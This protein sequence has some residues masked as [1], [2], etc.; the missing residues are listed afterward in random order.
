MEAG[1]DLFALADTSFI[2][3]VIDESNAGH[4]DARTLYKSLPDCI[5]LPVTV[6]PELAFLMGRSGGTLSVVA[7]I[8]TLRA[9]DIRFVDLWPEDYD[10]TAEILE[11]YADT[12]IDFV[13]ATIMALAERLNVTRIL[14]L[15]RRD[16]AL[17]RPVHCSHF[18]ILP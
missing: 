3:A 16:F 14:T 5:L 2:F 15:D 11:E 9:S 10:R 4:K 8:R 17:Y 18:E 6:L 7:M 12:R 1:L 13:D